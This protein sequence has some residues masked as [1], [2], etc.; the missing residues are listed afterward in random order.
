MTGHVAFIDTIEG[1]ENE[2]FMLNG[3]LQEVEI[4]REQLRNCIEFAAK[5]HLSLWSIEAAENEA[6]RLKDRINA[7]QAMWEKQFS[8]IV[9]NR[10]KTPNLAALIE[11]AESSD[12]KV[13]KNWLTPEERQ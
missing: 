7:L 1:V 12:S 13:L 3:M 5:K 6:K 8:D 2:L 9:E 4:Y 10:K 11:A